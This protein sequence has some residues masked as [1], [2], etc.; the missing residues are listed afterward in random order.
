MIAAR[1]R[2]KIV[3]R[4][5][6]NGIKPAA[7]MSFTRVTVVIP[8][9]ADAMRTIGLYLRRLAVVPSH[10]NLEFT[11]GEAAGRRGARRQ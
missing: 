1:T 6:P 11:L 10:V 3:A 5:E 7:S 4:K 2:K 9:T 8:A